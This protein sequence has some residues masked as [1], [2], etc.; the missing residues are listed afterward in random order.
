MQSMVGKKNDAVLMHNIM[1]A[2]NE[3]QQYYIRA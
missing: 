2:C 3:M 1:E